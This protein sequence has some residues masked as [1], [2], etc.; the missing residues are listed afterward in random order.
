MKP[1]SRARAYFRR[2]AERGLRAVVKQIEGTYLAPSLRSSGVYY[3]GGYVKQWSSTE[4]VEE[5]MTST[6]WVYVCA[7]AIAQALAKLDWNAYQVGGDG[8]QQRLD[9]AHPLSVLMDQPNSYQ[10]ELAFWEQTAL[11]LLMSG[12]VMTIKLYDAVDTSRVAALQTV[13][14][15]YLTPVPGDPRKGQPFLLGYDWSGAAYGCGLPRMRPQDVIHVKLPDPSTPYWGMS[16]MRAGAAVVATDKAASEWN[17]SAMDNRVAPSGILSVVGPGKEPLTDAQWNQVRQQ[18]WDQHQRAAHAREPFV[19]GADMNWTSLGMSAEDLDFINGR[20]MSR[21]EICALFHVPPPVVGIQDS[22]T[23]NNVSEAWLR[24]YLDTIFPAADRFADAFTV[25]LARTFG[26]DLAIGYERV[27]VQALSKILID[28]ADTFVKLFN[29]GL[30]PTVISGALGI[31]L[32]RYAG[33]A[34]GWLPGG[35]LPVATLAGAEGQDAAV[36]EAA[37]AEEPVDEEA[38]RTALTG[39]SKARLAE[40]YAKRM[41]ARPAP[42]SVPPRGNG[43]SNG[44]KHAPPVS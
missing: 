19:V 18:L 9:D 38:A 13:R 3:G 6:V 42:K 37:P 43:R 10:G 7:T 41:G 16:P 1:F 29:C 30:P 33:D 5:G 40:V 34:I 28:Y 15:D 20:R 11:M 32:P 22:A 26:A 39:R 44:R 35:L 31:D 27:G 4:A 17:M 2:L 21:E 12:N 24:F 8:A 36:E 14:S 23:Y 25:S